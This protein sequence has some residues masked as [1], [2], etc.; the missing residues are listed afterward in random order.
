[1]SNPGFT[2]TNKIVY[3]EPIPSFEDDTHIITPST[4]HKDLWVWTSK[5]D[6][7]SMFC[8]TASLQWLKDNYRLINDRGNALLDYFAI[9]KRIVSRS[10][11]N[12]SYKDRC[13]QI[14]TRNA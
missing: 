3:Q 12:H 6:S 13:R 14:R 8:I 1:M 5:K 2:V 10:R 11:T 7:T 9:N 4:S